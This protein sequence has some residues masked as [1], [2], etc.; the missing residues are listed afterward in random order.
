MDFK[1][2]DFTQ[3]IDM[4]RGQMR[5]FFWQDLSIRSEKLTVNNEMMC[6]DR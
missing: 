3:S 1:P 5:S 2:V 6:N 4:E